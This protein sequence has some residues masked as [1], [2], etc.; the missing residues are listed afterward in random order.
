[1]AMKLLIH[2]GF[3]KTGTSWLQDSVFSKEVLFN[4]L[5][6]HTEI[7]A[8][9]VRLHDLDFDPAEVHSAAKPRLAAGQ[10]GSIPVV[11]SEILSGTM[12]DGSRDSKVLADR[13]KASFPEAKILLT[14]RNQSSILASVYVQYLK[15]GGRKKFAEFLNYSCEPGYRWFV[16]SCLNLGQLTAYYAELYG[17]ENV[18][19]LPQELLARERQAYLNMLINFAS[20]G[21]AQEYEHEVDTKHV[22]K[23][24]PYS[25]LFLLRLGNLF[26]T[27]P[28]NPEAISTLSWVGTFAHKLAYSWTIGDSAARRKVMATSDTFVAGRFGKDNALLQSYCPVDLK[29]LGYQL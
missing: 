23:S 19:V 22:G 27:R 28:L 11:S 24:P 17:K 21:I 7:D 9:L 8:L 20:D 16:P 3:H 29:E 4:S 26:G 10:A 1:M 5:F 2:P 15:R 13:L 12:F 25:G 14:V 6:T 18:L